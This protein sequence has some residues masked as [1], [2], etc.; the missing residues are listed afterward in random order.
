MERIDPRMLPAAR[1]SATGSPRMLSGMLQAGKDESG[2]Q[3]TKR[4]KAGAG[5]RNQG[6]K[7]EGFPRLIAGTPHCRSVSTAQ[8]SAAN[9][10][11]FQKNTARNSF[12]G[13][14]FTERNDLEV[15]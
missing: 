4:E 8:L 13:L 2:N 10:R 12:S 11:I 7:V 14:E 6:C 15:S 5:V 1:D 9:D 3:E